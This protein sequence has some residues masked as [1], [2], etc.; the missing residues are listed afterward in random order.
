MRSHLS[1]LAAIATLIA[2]LAGAPGLAHAGGDER[3]PPPTGRTGSASAWRA[4]AYDD[5]H[6]TAR[7]VGDP[8]TPVCAVETILA[9]FIRAGNFCR[10]VI[11]TAELAERLARM[12]PRP[13]H[14]SRYRIAGAVR[15]LIPPGSIF[16]GR[17]SD[18][19]AIRRGDIYV[20]VFEIPCAIDEPDCVW[21]RHY[22]M[23]FWTRRIANQ[24]M[25]IRWTTERLE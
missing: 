25:V 7:C 6:T 22:T 5:A 20:T 14:L 10:Q 16:E 8:K 15:G 2:S 1:L 21:D 12:Q 13:H 23:H 19:R 24:W 3:A 4:I 17:P 18:S 9:C 11:A